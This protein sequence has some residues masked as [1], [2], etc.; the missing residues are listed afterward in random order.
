M[1][2]LFD[3]D[4][5]AELLSSGRFRMHFDAM[6]AVTGP[7]ASEI[8]ERRLGATSGTVVNGHP[9]PDFGGLHPDPNLINAPNCA[10]DERLGAPDLGAASDGDGDRNMI[11]GADLRQSVR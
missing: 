1:E 9:L 4:R 11:L 8:L 6:H 10:D 7:Y 2:S 5:I 3:F